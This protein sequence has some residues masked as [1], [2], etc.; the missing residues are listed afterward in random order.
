M[1]FCKPVLASLLHL[2][3]L[4]IIVYDIYQIFSCV[5]FFCL[6]HSK[7]S[8]CIDSETK[9]YALVSALSTGPEVHLELFLFALSTGPELH[10]ELFLSLLT[11]L[12][13]KYI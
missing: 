3:T 7:I 13:L 4:K 5:L 6:Y 10:L 11:Q 8:I 9:L 2:C 12:D 1:Y